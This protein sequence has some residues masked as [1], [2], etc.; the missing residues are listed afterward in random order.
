MF[1]NWNFCGDPRLTITMFRFFF[2]DPS[3]TPKWGPDPNSNV[4]VCLVAGVLHLSRDHGAGGCH[5]PGPEWTTVLHLLRPTLRDG[6]QPRPP[7]LIMCRGHH[8]LVVL[9]YSHRKDTVDLAIA[10]I[11]WRGNMLFQRREKMEVTLRGLRLVT[12]TGTGSSCRYLSISQSGE[13]LF[14][15]FSLCR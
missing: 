11:V 7:P 2:S 9:F 10:Y 6:P 15:Y 14:C 4:V 1:S 12:H 5:Q 8:F 13:A 3:Q